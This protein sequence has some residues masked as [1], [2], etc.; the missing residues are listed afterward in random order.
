MKVEVVYAL[1]NAQGCYLSTEVP[2]NT[3][4]RQALNHIGF[5]DLFPEVDFINNKVGVFGKVMSPDDMLNEG[6]RVEIYRAIYFDVK[7]TRQQTV[8]QKKQ[9]N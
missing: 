4:I 5:F 6:D 3:T 9:R 8:K 2:D 7:S 1:P